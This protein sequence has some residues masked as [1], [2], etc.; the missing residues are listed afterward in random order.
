ME[1]REWILLDDVGV[2]CGGYSVVRIEE[3]AK[4][5]ALSFVKRRSPE[6]GKKLKIAAFPAMDKILS[7][8]MTS[9]RCSLTKG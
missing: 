4:R 5:L 6:Q 9:S 3:L 2:E 8:P 1:V 7:V